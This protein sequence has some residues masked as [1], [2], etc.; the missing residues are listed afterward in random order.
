MYDQLQPDLDLA[1]S[2]AASYFTQPLRLGI[3]GCGYVTAMSHLP[4]A[5]LLDTIQIVAL[6]DV[7]K[8]SAQDLAQRYNVPIC[9]SD[10]QQIIEHV[11]AVIVAVPHHLHAP[12]AVDFLNNGIHVLVEKPMALRSAECQQMIDAAQRS[13]AK[14][15]VG[16]VRRFYDS[17]QLVKRFIDTG[18][19]GSVKQ[20]HAEEAVLF[21]RFAASAFT[22][23]PP[24]GGVLL[25]TGPHVLDML[26]WWL[27]N[28]AEFR[29]WDDAISGVEANCRIEA[30]TENGIPGNI[31]L[32]RTR[33]LD[34]KIR[35]E[36]E[37]G[38]LEISTLDPSQL[39]IESE[40]FT[41]PIHAGRSGD[42]KEIRQI[43]PYFARQLDDF[44][45]AICEDSA[46]AISGEE[47]LRSVMLM[48]A[49]KAQRT[50][51]P[52]P[53]WAEIDER[54]TRRVDL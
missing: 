19:L 22:L 2:L 53:S 35:L 37:E 27:G 49:C 41:G 21:E 39:H 17:S 40:R 32:S 13:N 54:I 10:Y 23:R 30:I 20:F 16:M 1:P 43:V 31:E 28:F 33:Q 25:D 6:A 46:P 52:T 11:D 5:Q 24:T 26:L 45:R 50:L 47:G 38:A 29:Y 14:L 12:I 34:N 48:E 36:C 15:A 18:F 8:K 44:A 9:G 7:N 42:E 3:V 51:L 4:A